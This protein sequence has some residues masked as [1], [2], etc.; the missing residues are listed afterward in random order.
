MDG[1]MDKCLDVEK[2]ERGKNYLAETKL[3]KGYSQP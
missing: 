1:Q 2:W 3:I